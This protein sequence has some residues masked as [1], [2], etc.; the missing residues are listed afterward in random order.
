MMGACYELEIEM[1]NTGECLTK[2]KEENQYTL[3]EI[4]VKN[5]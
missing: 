2:D 5:S 1:S 3:K 4:V